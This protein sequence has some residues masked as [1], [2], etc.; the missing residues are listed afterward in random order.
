M[1][2]ADT[3]DNSR[4]NV[5]RGDRLLAIREKRGMS[6]DEL[7]RLSLVAGNQIYRYEKRGYEPTA[8]V[9]A[10]LAQALDVTT[11]YLLGITDSESGEVHY[12]DL[13]PEERLWLEEKRATSSTTDA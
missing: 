7:G 9:V 5:F 10:R 3:K 11:D 6:R 13:S 2:M 4:E 12:E 1:D 8:A